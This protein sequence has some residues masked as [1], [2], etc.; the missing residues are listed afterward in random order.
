MMR[1]AMR[2]PEAVYAELRDHAQKHMPRE[3]GAL[4]LAGRMRIAGR[5]TLLVRRAILLDTDDFDRQETLRLVLKPRVINAAIGLCEANR[6]GIVFCHSHPGDIPYS[7]S[8]DIGESRLREVFD[9]C[10][11][12]APFGSLLLC[13]NLTFA[14]VWISPGHC[15]PIEQ[16]RL[17]GST[18][19]D[20]ILGDSEKQVALASANEFDRQERALGLEGQRRISEMKV[21]VVGLVGQDHLPRSNW[22]GSA[23]GISSN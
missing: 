7:V 16:V 8:D 2:V 15:E 11:P 13:P 6:L 18:I 5:D 21:A 14:R 20:L 22:C 10:L 17:I 3:V 19:R 23:L 12:N 4:M 9:Q 1:Y